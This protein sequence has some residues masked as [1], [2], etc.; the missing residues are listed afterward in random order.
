MRYDFISIILFLMLSGSPV[1]VSVVA[2]R[3]EG[4]FRETMRWDACIPIG[5]K[6]E[7]AV[8]R[9]AYLP[10]TSK[11]T[12]RKEQSSVWGWHSRQKGMLDGVIFVFHK[13]A[14]LK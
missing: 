1:H 2:R 10:P 4:L 8:V 13:C 14:C 5:E 6:V 9:G 3:V 11:P 12:Q 7:A